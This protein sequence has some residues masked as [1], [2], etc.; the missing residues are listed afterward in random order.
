[1]PAQVEVTQNAATSPVTQNAHTITGALDV[2]AGGGIILTNPGNRYGGQIK[3]DGGTT[4]AVEVTAQKLNIA[5]L[6][7]GNNE[8]LELRAVGRAATDHLELAGTISLVSRT[9]DTVLIS[10]HGQ[11]IVGSGAGTIQTAGNIHVGAGAGLNVG[12]VKST[13]TAVATGMVTIDG[14]ILLSDLEG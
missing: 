14:S 9:M 8:L 1:M 12:A 5:A 13:A 3:L 2:A 7:V 4:G 10:D 6:T 11:L